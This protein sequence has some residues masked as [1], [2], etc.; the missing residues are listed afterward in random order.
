VIINERRQ[1]DDQQARA[2]QRLFFVAK[3]A[4][5]C[6]DRRLRAGFASLGG[7]MAA[8]S[9]AVDLTNLHVRQRADRYR[10][11]SRPRCGTSTPRGAS[12]ERSTAVGVAGEDVQERLGHGNI[13]MTH[14]SLGQRR[15]A[16]LV[17]ATITQ[18]GDEFSNENNGST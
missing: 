16:S 13:A 10:A 17:D 3:P 7:S 9:D 11:A 6:G 5:I 14:V 1:S 2:A 15:L 8:H 4:V 12:I 18:Y